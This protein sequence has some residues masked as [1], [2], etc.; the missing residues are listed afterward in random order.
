MKYRYLLCVLAI[1]VHSL[2]SQGAE[3]FTALQEAT[4][5]DEKRAEL[6]K[7]LYFDP[8]LSK[9]GYI[10]CNSCHNLSM[11][12]SDNLPTSIGHGWQEGSMNSPTVLNSRFN[13]AQFWDGRSAD[14]QAQAAGPIA[15]PGEMA[16][17]HDLAVE[18]V[19]TIPGYVQ[20]MKKVY[21]DERVTIDRLTDAIAEFERTLVTPDSPFDLWLKGDS[22]AM[23]KPAL[24]GYELFKGTGCAACHSGPA[25]GGGMFQKV[26]LIQPY[27]T[28]NPARGRAG[29]TGQPH[30]E[31]VFKVPTLRN[32][33]LT[34]PYFHDGQVSTLEE[35][36]DLM[37]Q[38]Q[39]GRQYSDQEIDQL[40][41]FLR[42]LTGRQPDFPLPQLPP[43]SPA[44]PQPDPFGP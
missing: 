32:I 36:I 28:D 3:P 33:E 16:S 14:L 23:S 18:V 10:S 38:L 7:Q 2:G 12:G 15:N 39:L 1:S 29:I 41:A 26:G 17:T 4:D 34:Y 5:I 43:S 44:T 9:S 22:T 27:T 24:A 19:A 40:A 8:R 42:S 13:I 35:A 11:G 6:G 25:L 21:G 30:D 37:G 20:Q 31:M